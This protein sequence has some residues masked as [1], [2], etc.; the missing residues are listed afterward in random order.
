MQPRAL[1]TMLAA[2]RHRASELHQVQG[3]WRIRYLALV[4]TLA[5]LTACGD[6]D[7]GPG[8]QQA[9]R[10]NQLQNLGTHNSYHSH[11]LEGPIMDVFE[12]RYPWFEREHYEYR[13]APLIKQLQEQ[14]V[15]HFEIDVYADYEGGLFNTIPAMA[16]L[17]L[18]IERNIPALDEPGFKVLHMPQLDPN[19]TCLTLIECMQ[20]IKT[21]SDA[22]SHHQPLL[23]MVEP[24]FVDFLGIAP[25]I[26]LKP[27]TEL[28]YQAMDDDILSVFPRDRIIT[29]DKVQ[30]NYPTLESAVLAGNWPKLEESRGKIILLLYHGRPL[31]DTRGQIMFPVTEPGN[32]GAA[33]LV[34]EHIERDYEKVADWVE[35]GYMVRVRADRDLLEAANKDR[36]KFQL[37]LD[38]GAQF[39]STDIPVPSPIYPGF[40]FKIPDG[41]PARCNPV[42]A[43]AWCRSKDIE[44]PEKLLSRNKN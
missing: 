23:V 11:P 3:F 36:G 17:G 8:D 7:R 35:R 25:Y 9:L 15:R 2:K 32:P 42:T 16:E 37:A 24:K 18:P 28:D 13:H 4:A 10:I 39:I 6:E 44:D 34:V 12:Q 20:Q 22:H 5:L 38:S 1:L 29:P 31:D 40:Y 19:S 21:W 43:P 33:I 41:T 26:K 14:G 30:G 27:F